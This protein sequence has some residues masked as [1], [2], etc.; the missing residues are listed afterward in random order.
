VVLSW[1]LP[2]GAWAAEGSSEI[3]GTWSSDDADHAVIA[4]RRCPQGLCGDVLRQ[5]DTGAKFEVIGSFQRVSDTHWTGG[6]IYNLNDGATYVV[7]LRLLDAARLDARACWLG[8]CEK[9]LW[10]RVE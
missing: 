8:F 10:R 1:L 9:Q 4:L 5:P 7:E 3:A 6:R 2:L